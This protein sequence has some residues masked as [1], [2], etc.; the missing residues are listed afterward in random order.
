MDPKIGHFAGS[1]TI[2]CLPS[3][4]IYMHII[5]LCFKMERKQVCKQSL[6]VVKIEYHYVNTKNSSKI[7]FYYNNN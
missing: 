5:I 6:Y 7:D 4:H 2:V 1:I 3:V